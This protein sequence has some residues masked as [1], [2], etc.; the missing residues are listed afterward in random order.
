MQPTLHPGTLNPQPPHSVAKVEGRSMQ[1]TLNPEESG[2]RDRVLIDKFSF[3]T[4][5]F[6]FQR[7]LPNPRDFFSFVALSFGSREPL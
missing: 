1:P 6:G 5:S 2:P 3:G 7:F 4:L